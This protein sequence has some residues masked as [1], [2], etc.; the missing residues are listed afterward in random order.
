MRL[1]ALA[2]LLAALLA[3][4]AAAVSSGAGRDPLSTDAL[5]RDVRT[6]AALAPTHL[7]GTDDSGVTQ[8]WMAR[9]LRAA[10]VRTGADA[11]SFF[12]F[13]P[14]AVAL[15]ADGRPVP[16][17]VARLYS[18]TTPTAGLRAPLATGDGDVKGKIAVVDVPAADGLTPTLESAIGKAEDGG[19]A[20]LV[21]VTEG[22]EDY[23]VQEDVDSRAGLLGMPVVFV[24]KRSGAAVLDA[25]KAG[26][27][28]RLTLTADVG[29]GCDSNVYGVLPGAD[30]SRTV[31]IGTPTGAFVPSASER[32]VGVAILLGL[33]R[34]YAA[35]PRAQRPVTLVFAALAGHEAGYLGLPVLMQVHKDWFAKGDAYFHLGASLAARAMTE[36]PGGTVVGG[37]AGDPTRLLYVSENPL[38]QGIAQKDFATSQLG[39]GAPGVRNVGEQVYAYHAGVPVI[40]SS[41]SSFYFHT[42]GDQPDGVSRTLL[43][44]VAGGF[45]AAIDDVAA[46]PPGALRGANGAAAALGARQDP[47][48]TPGGGNGAADPA[49]EPKPVAACAGAPGTPARTTPAQQQPTGVS[50]GLGLIPGYEDLQPAFAWQGS[51]QSRTFRF[52]SRATGAMLSGHVFAPDPLPPGGMRL[53]VVVIGPGSGPGVETMY[54]WAARDL[55]GHGYV[56]V[57]IDPQGVG[58]SETFPPGGVT[59]GVPFQQSG[60]YVDA[61]QSGID[62]ALSSRNPWRSRTDPR[63]IGIAGH[64]L[65]A[66]AGSYLQGTDH[67][68]RALVAWDNLAS[69]LQGDA[70]SP[71]GGGAA[72]S[73]IGG[74]LPGGAE[75]VTPRVPA[76]GE[77][78]DKP[79][80]TEPANTDPD[81][82]KTAFAAWRKAGRPAMEVV[83]AG[84]GHID[85]AQAMSNR[86]AAEEAKLTLFEYYTRAWFDRWLRGDRSATGRLLAR[87]VGGTPVAGVMSPKWRSGAWF[88]GHDCQDVRAACPAAP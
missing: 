43:A 1:L 5:M 85:W 70:G 69:D 32:G 31:V 15:E 11:F 14:R 48:A 3:A 77:S 75:P 10:G 19:A 72:G 21:A 47:G 83:F 54:H 2:L 52:P 84:T 88:D 66:R 24:G 76:L 29:T 57:A 7:S 23:A 34:H 87:T 28:G 81:E 45:R 4:A 58:R 73:L 63:R 62:F 33:A 39:S 36:T 53:P 8:A 64:S 80:S 74:E 13:T 35:L 27:Q 67:R 44:N 55:A 26:G 9:R 59:D 50:A 86:G 38:A 40:S 46:L 61:L 49:K 22:P 12:R 41:G 78:N 60:N 6:Y 20:A 37:E 42:D 65:A 79:G 18:G 51:W 25:A 17:V 68:V 71:S 82:K 16:G 30:A 56:A